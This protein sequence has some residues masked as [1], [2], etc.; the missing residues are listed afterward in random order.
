MSKI[1]P[2][3]FY[4]HDDEWLRVESDE[5]LVGISDHAQDALSDIVYLELP[6]VGDTF[7]QGE[8]FGVVESVKAAADL[9]MPVAGEVIAVNDALVDSPEQLNSAPYASWL[10]RIKLSDPNEV[11]TLMDAVAY[12]AH[13]ED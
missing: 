1:E 8:A 11:G 9:F 5:A 12:A 13:H 2:G 3:L 4:T 10:I 6:N 7:A